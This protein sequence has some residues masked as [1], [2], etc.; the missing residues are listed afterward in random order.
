[1]GENLFSDPLHF[2][3]L[4]GKNLDFPYSRQ[5]VLQCRIEI[6]EHSLGMAKQGPDVAVV[7][8]ESGDDERDWN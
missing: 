6:A 5:V 7:Q 4:L 1:M 8:D 2:P 3:F